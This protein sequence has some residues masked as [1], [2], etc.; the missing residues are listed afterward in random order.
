M[1]DGSITKEQAIALLKEY[2]TRA[3]GVKAFASSLGIST[4][5]VSQQLHGH[6]PIHG[7][8]ADHLGLKAHRETTIYYKEA[9][10]EGE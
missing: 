10:N 9:G 3:G 5:A 1:K 7:K 6:K 8:V 2:C 4:G